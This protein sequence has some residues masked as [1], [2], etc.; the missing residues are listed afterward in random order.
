MCLVTI[1]GLETTIQAAKVLR[2]GREVGFCDNTLQSALRD[3]G[4][5]A[6][7]KLPKPC[8]SEK[9]VQEKLQF[10]RIHK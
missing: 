10:A 8:L 3:V 9:N 7:E 2:E 4:L 5:S 1:G 6:C